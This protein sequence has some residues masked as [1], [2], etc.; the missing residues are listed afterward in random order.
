M[1]PVLVR[2][3]I[4]AIA[5]ALSTATPS[6]ANVGTSN[7]DAL[8]LS[9]LS[10][11]H[12]SDSSLFP[13]SDFALD[14]VIPL[15]DAFTLSEATDQTS[16]VSLSSL[17]SPLSPAPA[18]ADF[19]GPSAAAA[20]QGA[21]SLPT[22]D[23]RSLGSRMGAAKWEA[24]G[25]MAYTTAVQSLLTNPNTDF[26]FSHEGWFGKDTANLGI[27]KLTHAFNAYI[28]SEFLGHRIARKTGDRTGSALP[29][30]LMGFGLQFYGELWDAHKTSSGFSMEDV[31]FNAL[32]SAFSY[33]RHTVPGLEEKLDF[34]LMTIPNSKGFSRSGKKHYEQQHFLFAVKLAGFEK[35]EASPL[36]FVELHVGYRGKDFTN[37]E[38]AAGVTPKRDIFFGLALNVSELFFKN[39]RSRLGR[40][41][42]SGL[43]Y[44]Q[45]P[46]V[47]TH[48][49]DGW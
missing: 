39:S 27:D 11:G 44:F 40:A 8:P 41:V 16:F 31:T 34:R 20:S 3:A 49:Y 23:Y 2:L 14:A 10:A 32:G 19:I 9:P 26:H 17:A 22:R 12:G 24:L 30:A 36:R 25:I 6:H 46:Y 48:N 47:A 42:A 4:P 18:P 45:I 21:A 28:F 43:N 33:A 15:P 13:P 5:L 38:R 7:I 35:L 37:A 29:A 1:G